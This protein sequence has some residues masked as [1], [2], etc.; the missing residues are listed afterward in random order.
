LLYHQPTQEKI[1]ESFSG[2]PAFFGVSVSGD[3]IDSLR[4]LSLRVEKAMRQNREL[5]NIIN[6]ARFT[7]PEIE[8]RPRRAQLARYGLNAGQLLQQMSLAFR[9][10]VVARFVKEQAPVAVFLRLPGSDRKNT[11]QLQNLPIRAPSGQYIPLQELASITMRD[12]MPALTHL[13]G[14]REVTLIAEP[15]GNLW[16]IVAHLRER[17]KSL[18]FPPGYT[19][20]VRAQYQTL[21]ESIRSFALVILAAVVFVYLLLYLQFNSFWQP[22]VILLKVPLDF[23]GAFVAVLLTRQSIN[24]SVGIGLLTLVGVSVNNAI[25][26]LDMVNHLRREQDLPLDEALLQAVHLRTR[27]IL[28]TGLTTILGL[29]PAAIG[30]GIGSKIHQPFAITVIGGMITGILFSLNAIPALYAAFAGRRSKSGE[31]RAV[32]HTP[33]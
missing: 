16:A 18:A 32:G 1:D 7:V 6:N 3:N 19:Y 12:I 4:V 23:I 29:L 27:P 8:I 31:N 26:L 33:S 9:G 5:S 30:F 24:I 10:Q 15:E 22:F 11:A 21:L 13:N 17:F 2:L 14:Q 25:I 20:R 28:M